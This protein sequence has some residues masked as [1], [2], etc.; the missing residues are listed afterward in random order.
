MAREVSRT[1]MLE[2]VQR[3]KELR[4]VLTADNIRQ[5]PTFICHCCKCCCGVLLGVTRHGY[6]N[7]IITSSYIARV[8]EDTCT[9][10]ELCAKNCPV[11]AIG[12]VDGGQKDG[13]KAKTPRVNQDLCLGCGVCGLVC[14]K[15]AIKLAKRN[16][17]I[18]QPQ[19]TFERIIL[20]CLERGT[21]QNQLFDDPASI[22]HKAMRGI[23][24]AFFGLRPVQRAL[25]SD[26][27]R[28]VF[29]SSMKTGARLQGR[30]I[31]TRM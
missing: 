29:L 7:H 5:E 16:K 21:L 26:Q 13:N 6:P 15:N 24:G 3:S 30:Q 27:L 20:Q 14:K 17:R 25:M 11:D 12:M 22:S 31:L 10:C 23:L 8:D 4:L 2:N 28:S 1:E 18:I 19:T 9:G